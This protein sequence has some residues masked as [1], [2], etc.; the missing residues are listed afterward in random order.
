MLDKILKYGLYLLVFLTPIFFL[1][2]TVLPVI[3]NKQMLLSVLAFLL[4]IFWMLKIMITGKLKLA[5]GRISWSVLL[6]I[7]ILG[8]STFASGA[9]TQS[10]W[11]MNFE[12][13]TFY[14]FVLYALVFFLVSNLVEKQDVVK[15]LF[16]FLASS[17]V[18]SL[19]FLVQSL[20]GPVFPWDFAQ[21]AG[22]NPIGSVQGLSVFLGGMFILLMGLIN[23][24]LVKKRTRILMGL[25]GVLLFLAIFLINSWVAWLGIV[26]GTG[27]IVW[28]MIKNI[29]NTFAEQDFKKFILPLFILVFALIFLNFPFRGIVDLP[30]EISLTHLATWDIAEKTLKQSTKNL[31]LG[32]GPATFLYQHNLLRGVELNLSDFWQLQFEQGSSAFLTFLTGFGIAG[33]LILLT[34]VIIFLWQGIQRL[35]RNE[36]KNEQLAVFAAGVYALIVSAFYAVNLSLMFSLFLM[37]GLW[38][39]LTENRK[40]FL[41]TQ[42]P[43]KAFLI[44]LLG[45]VSMAGSVIVIYNVSQKYIA[46]LNYAQGIQAIN[47]LGQEPEDVRSAKLN[48]AIVKIS[49][50]TQLDPKDI[51]F[52]NLSQAFLIQINQII[53]NEGLEQEQMQALFQQVI[54]NVELSATASVQ[55]NPANSQ[56]LVQL[57]RV[58]ENMGV[59]NVEGANDLAIMSFEQARELE[60]QNPFI[61]FNIARVYLTKQELDKAKEEVEKSLELKNDFQIAL[62][63][64]EEIKSQEETESPE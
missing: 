63:L 21:G 18:L 13:D 47:V 17:G 57:G 5:W 37:L 23:S 20:I 35:R 10:L 22:F 53:S 38:V 45:V 43:Q 25:L 15:I 51:Y 1:P 42:S 55:V 58:Y 6:L 49:K 39:S 59:L 61:P 40:E 8:I 33:S 54:S 2:A 36:L 7:I 9:R 44:M 16:V 11:G 30:G 62:S 27:I 46:A 12:P 64:M 24:D 50:A 34:I 28:N 29:E 4:F 31:I 19:M 14:S 52:R 3:I 32:S 41:F 48:E 60:P 56:N 26:F